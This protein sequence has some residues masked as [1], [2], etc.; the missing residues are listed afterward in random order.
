MQADDRL[1]QGG[2]H[3]ANLSVPTLG[4][5]YA[6]GPRITGI[7]FDVTR[8]RWSRQGLRRTVTLGD[9][10]N[11]NARLKQCRVVG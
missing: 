3:F 11:D 6:N 8:L 5:G 7:A 1:A 2:H 9:G 4:Q 10:R